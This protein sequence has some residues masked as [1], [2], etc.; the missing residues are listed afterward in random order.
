MDAW[1]DTFTEEGLLS[2]LP[3]STRSLVAAMLADNKSIDEIGNLLAREPG[4]GVAPK[5]GKGW[6]ADL[7]PRTLVELRE[8]ICGKEQKYAALRNEISTKGALAS[9]AMI[10]PVASAISQ[11]LN[12]SEA[13]V[14]TY[15]VLGL[16]FVTTVGKEVLCGAALAASPPETTATPQSPPSQAANG[17]DDGDQDHAADSSPR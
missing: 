13:T 1:L 5:G 17:A 14:T 8:L 16:L 6:V 4:F 11:T 12:S 15:V 10:A 9:G 3:P 7:W 2:E